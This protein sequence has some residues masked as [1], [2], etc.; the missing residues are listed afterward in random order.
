VCSSDFVGNNW[1]SL[2]E[3]LG[4]IVDPIDWRNRAF[5][6]FQLLSDLCQLSKKTTND[7]VQRFLLQSF[8]ASS[9]LTESDFSTQFNATLNQFYQST[10]TYFNLLVDTVHLVVQSDQPHRESLRFYMNIFYTKLIVNIITNE[11]NNQQ[12]L[13][14]CLN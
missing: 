9:V 10:I 8:V 12:S 4:A 14:V 3:G 1:I 2:I 13:Q 11:T 5:S 7:A 6:Y